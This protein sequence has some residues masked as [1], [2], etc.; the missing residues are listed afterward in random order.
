MAVALFEGRPPRDPEK[1]RERL[2]VRHRARGPDDAAGV[3]AP[4]QEARRGGDPRQGALAAH[5]APRLRDPPAQPRRGPARRAAAARPRGHLDDADLHA[6][7][8]R[9]AQEAAPG[10]PPPRLNQLRERS[11]LTP[12]C[13]ASRSTP[14]L[15]MLTLTRG[16]LK[17][18]SI[19]FAMRSARLSTR[20]KRS[21]ASRARMRS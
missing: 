13:F 18:S 10:P 21:F 19:R 6:R 8:A 1:A 2:R 11:M 4:D 7:R 16:D 14:S 20:P 17:S 5:A 3:L 12:T 15:A 9:A